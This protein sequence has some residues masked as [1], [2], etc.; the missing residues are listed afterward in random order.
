[1]NML[2]PINSLHSSMIK[3]LNMSFIETSNITS[4]V[5]VRV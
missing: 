1:V 4:R 2:L 5:I 3:V